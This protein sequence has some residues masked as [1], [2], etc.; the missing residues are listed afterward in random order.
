[1][2]AGMIFHK[3]PF[4]QGKDNHDQLVKIAKVCGTQELYAYL[5]KYNIELEEDFIAMIG[6]HSK[7]EWNLLIKPENKH[8]CTEDALDLL[9]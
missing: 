5:D 3:E 8:L 7:K 2:F 4:F 1:M 6:T 9:S